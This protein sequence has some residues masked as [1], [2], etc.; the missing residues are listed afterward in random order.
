[1]AGRTR[2]GRGPKPS[3][4]SQYVPDFFS[5]LTS[6]NEDLAYLRERPA[7]KWVSNTTALGRDT[8]VPLDA[9]P[10]DLHALLHT[11]HDQDTSGLLKTALGVSYRVIANPAQQGKHSA[12]P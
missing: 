7:G 12:R 11:W 3:P 6:K 9:P 5:L 2:R 10:A 4:D 1:V 8:G